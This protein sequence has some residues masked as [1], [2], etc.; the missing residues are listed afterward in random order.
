MRVDAAA[1]ELHAAVDWT[2]PPLSLDK[3]FQAIAQ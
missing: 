2:V 3:D 1:P